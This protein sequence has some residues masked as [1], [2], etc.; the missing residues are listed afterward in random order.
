MFYELVVFSSEGACFCY[1][2]IIHEKRTATKLFPL[3]SVNGR[4]SCSGSIQD[5]SVETV[6]EWF[7]SVNKLLF[8]ITVLVSEWVVFQSIVID[9]VTFQARNTNLIIL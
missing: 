1:V 8:S 5:G 2:L 4:Q 3:D 9:T 7:C 6:P